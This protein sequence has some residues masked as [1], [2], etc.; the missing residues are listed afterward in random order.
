[1]TMLVG[2]HTRGIKPVREE[3]IEAFQEARRVCKASPKNLGGVLLA[4]ASDIYT[5]TEACTRVKDCA[6]R[7]TE[8]LRSCCDGSGIVGWRKDIPAESSSIWIFNELAQREEGPQIASQIMMHP[9]SGLILYTVTGISSITNYP[10]MEVSGDGVTSAFISEDKIGKKWSIKAIYDVWLKVE[11][12]NPLWKPLYDILKEF[13]D[14]EDIWAS[15][16]RFHP[17]DMK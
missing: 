8:I 17:Q 15:F 6:S 4:M 10:F 13:A 3:I 16:S 5:G 1:M 12:G 9:S 7:I 14:D 11:E 2:N